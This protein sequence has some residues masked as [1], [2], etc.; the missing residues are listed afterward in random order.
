LFHTAYLYAAVIGGS[1]H[2]VIEV[3]PHHVSYYRRALQ[4]KVIG[5]ERMNQRVLAPAV[6]LM[7]SFATIADGIARFAGRPDV[8][9]AKNSLFLHGFAEKDEA[10]VLNRLR[11][12]V[13]N[14]T[15]RP[16]AH[17]Q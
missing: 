1:T 12:L 9:G 7:V 10:G 13:E 3:N 11:T 2:A 4:F 16:L 6:L 5:P 8:P 17:G 15:A 14:S